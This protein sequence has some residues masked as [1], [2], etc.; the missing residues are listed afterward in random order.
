MNAFNETDASPAMVAEEESSLDRPFFKSVAAAPAVA[1]PRWAGGDVFHVTSVDDA[2]NCLHP[3]W[4]WQ[5]IPCRQ[6]VIPRPPCA[7]KHAAFAF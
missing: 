7:E 1:G 3:R 5:M 4:D 2:A 6:G